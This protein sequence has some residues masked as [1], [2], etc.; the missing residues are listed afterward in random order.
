MKSKCNNIW[1]LKQCASKWAVALTKFNI[2]M[3][4]IEGYEDLDLENLNEEQ[5]KQLYMY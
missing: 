1:Q 4:F 5:L 3:V 2:N